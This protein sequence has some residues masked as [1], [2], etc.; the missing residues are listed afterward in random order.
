MLRLPVDRRAVVAAAVLLAAMLAP[1][2]LP[3]PGGAAP[4]PAAPA[5]AA[6]AGAPAQVAAAKRCRRGQAQLRVRGRGR[7]VATRG[8]LRGLPSSADGL[9]GALVRTGRARDRAKGARSIAALLGSDAAAIARWEDQVV[10]VARAA[11]TRRLTAPRTRISTPV[12]RAAEGDGEEALGL[13]TTSTV[14]GWVDSVAAFVGFGGDK[15]SRRGG[16]DTSRVVG[17]LTKG[18]VTYEVDVDETTP[19]G[20]L[21][22]QDGE[23]SARGG[24]KVRRTV[25]RNGKTTTDSLVVPY[26]VHGRVGRDAKL[27]DY[28][29]FV[30]TG[31]ATAT[32]N[33]LKPSAVGK[34][35]ILADEITIRSTSPQL[36]PDR[37]LVAEAMRFAQ[38]RAL[39]F[40]DE[41]QDV[42]NAEQSC[43]KVVPTPGR[44][45]PGTAQ[46]VT[47][48]TFSTVTGKAIASDLDLVPSGGASVTPA[49]TA[50]T[51][52]KPATVR[53]TMPKSRL[54]AGGS[55]GKVGVT[56]TSPEGRA[57]SAIDSFALP[58][59]FDVVLHVDGLANFA[60]HS[61]TGSIDVAFQ[62]T[63]D[64]ASEAVRWAGTATATWANLAVTS[65]T[66]CS[67]DTPVTAP[68]P[69][70]VTIDPDAAGEQG[71]VT[72]GYGTGTAGAGSVL[73]T[74]WTVHC[75][76]DPPPPPIDGQP[77]PSLVAFGPTTFT[78]PLTGGTQALTTGSGV[79]DGGEG[80]FSSGTMRITPVVAR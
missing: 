56:A 35:L 69:V 32:I 53:V 78:V 30:K 31:F 67:Y 21:C 2:V 28:G 52:S 42:W 12:A 29:I 66:D 58:A 43:V 7:C 70:T 26:N 64:P 18:D 80:F 49:K 39:R 34:A 24:V 57:T 8:L 68:G 14:Q 11:I 4:A 72:F 41:A 25:T 17:R 36:A 50:T 40:L 48:R 22:P 77:G 1:A 9:V 16:G 74:S 5:A 61:S 23:V 73:A 60:T 51:R 63:R 3:S 65:K 47:I 37:D 38:E 20:I 75:P 54:R 19:E 76:G 15:E 46:T 13:P 59:A 6:A 44:V 62:A 71:S 45:A 55:G 10:R 27:I 79:Q 33:G